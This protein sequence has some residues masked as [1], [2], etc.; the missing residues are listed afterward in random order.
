[1][2]HNNGKHEKSNNNEKRYQKHP[3]NQQGA[4]NNNCRYQN[5]A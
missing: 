2:K 4:Q 1:M 5:I 3:F